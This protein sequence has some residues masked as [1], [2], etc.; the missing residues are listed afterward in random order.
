MVLSLGHKEMKNFL[1][2]RSAFEVDQALVR[3]MWISLR[4][5]ILHRG[6]R[7]MC[8]SSGMLQ[9]LV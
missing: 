2:P 7:V 5:Y 6:V 4:V 9:M 8:K 3:Q 1:S